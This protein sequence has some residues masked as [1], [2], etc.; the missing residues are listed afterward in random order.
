M[1]NASRDYDPRRAEILEVLVELYLRLNGYFSIRNYLQHRV[2]KFGLLT[3]FDLLAVRMPYQE[4]V[5]ENG[6]RQLNDLTLILPEGDST[7]DCVIAEVKEPS[8]EFNRPIQRPDGTRLIIAGL[9]MFGVLP[10]DTFNERGLAHQIAT[11]LH[12]K[13]NNDRW[14]ELPE[15]HDA[16]HKISFRM[17]VFAPSTATRANE[18]KHFDLQHVLDFTKSRMRPGE[19]CA[20]YRDLVA[21]SAS[22]WRGCTRLIVETLDASHSEGGTNLPLEEFVTRVLSRLAG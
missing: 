15:S 20:T 7:V 10:K 13:I 2:E 8:V 19:A 18:R 22:P 9:R 4:E 3:E 11:D 5:L 14:T 21:P 1:G 17:L 12:S 6:H 16:E